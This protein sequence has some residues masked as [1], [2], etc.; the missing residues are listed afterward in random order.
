MHRLL[1]SLHFREEGH[2]QSPVA[3][4]IF[5]TAAKLYHIE[6]LEDLRVSKES[7]QGISG[8][9]SALNRESGGMRGRHSESGV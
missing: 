8:D 9:T 5:N 6:I 3:I 7:V 2:D 4:S 1:H